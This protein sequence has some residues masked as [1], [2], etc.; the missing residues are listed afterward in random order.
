MPSPEKFRETP[1]THGVPDE[2]VRD[3]YLNY[4]NLASKTSKKI[5]AAFEC[6][7]PTIPWAKSPAFSA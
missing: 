7:C 4:P 2:I 5:K 6:A 3:M 1:D